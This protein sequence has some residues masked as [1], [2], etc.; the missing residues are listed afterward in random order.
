MRATNE[1][2][3]SNAGLERRAS[4]S[5]TTANSNRL[6]TLTDVNDRYAQLFFYLLAAMTVIY[7]GV[8]ISVYHYWV[9]WNR[10]DAFYFAVQTITTVGKLF[11]RPR[12]KLTT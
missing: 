7:F 12:Y 4:L 5:D 1:E 3:R 6:L 11:R 8:G 9:G 10:L 2:N